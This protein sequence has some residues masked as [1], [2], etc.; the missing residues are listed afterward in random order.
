[1]SHVLIKAKLLFSDRSLGYLELLD[2]LTFNPQRRILFK[3]LERENI[4]KC[5]FLVKLVNTSPNK[6]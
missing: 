4:R 2:N 6:F 5:I 1:M 3:Y